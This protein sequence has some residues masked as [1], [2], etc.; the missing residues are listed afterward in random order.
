MMKKKW[1]SLLLASTGL[2]ASHSVLAATPNST[3][4][5]NYTQRAFNSAFGSNA[6]SRFK[7]NGFMS[8][9]V[10]V[11]DS[12]E[13]VPPN[14]GKVTKTPHFGGNTLFGLQLQANL[15]HN[16]DIVSQILVN[17]QDINGNT[18][19]NLQSDWIFARYKVN[20]F[21]QIRAG[22]FRLPTFLYSSTIDVGYTFPWTYLPS[23]YRTVPFNNM[24][25]LDLIFNIPLGQ[26]W[27]MKVQPFYGNSS[28]KY[29]YVFPANMA[30]SKKTVKGLPTQTV[31]GDFTE[32]N[33]LGVTASVSDNN[34]YVTLRGGYAQTQV[35]GHLDIPIVI[36]ATPTV[37]IPLNSSFTQDVSKHIARFYTAAAKVNY[38]NVLFL[39]EWAHRKT[40]D[41]IASLTS[42]YTT[43]GYH[44]KRFLPLFTYSQIK[45]T[46][47]Q[48]LAVTNNGVQ[49]LAESQRSYTLGLDYFF[50]NNLVLKSS[51]ALVE[52]LDGTM[53]LYNVLPKHKFG[54]IY[55]LTLSAVF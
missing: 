51:A 13:Y 54:Q 36:P 55:S 37:P 38:R 24:N 48:A 46:N 1:I 52:P 16:L 32:D 34:G 3:Q 43:L 47:Q 7:V 18:P 19:F 6:G 27:G 49:T 23:V 20:R 42:F 50:N 10:S 29:D 21:A 15:F 44:I 2:A 4:P 33:I 45:T 12:G 41:Q 30:D 17:G 39:S 31:T 22:R 40:D 25:G 5:T 8:T 53:G 28:S 26:N 35:S 9:G 11:A 14:I